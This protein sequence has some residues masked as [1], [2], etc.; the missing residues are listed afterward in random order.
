MT[1]T[2]N[3]FYVP[4]N[5]TNFLP[6]EYI[7]ASRSQ[8]LPQTYGPIILFIGSSLFFTAIIFLSVYILFRNIDNEIV[9]KTIVIISLCLGIL[10]AYMFPSLSLGFLEFF[11]YF[12]LLILII[13]LYAIFRMT[14]LPHKSVSHYSTKLDRMKMEEIKKAIEE[15]S[16]LDEAALEE[17]SKSKYKNLEVIYN[18]LSGSPGE[19]GLAKLA[20]AYKKAKSEEE[21]KEIM[22]R[23]ISSLIESGKLKVKTEKDLEKLINLINL[24]LGLND[25]NHKK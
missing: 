19:K 14:L 21:R 2:I 6:R 12:I 16:Q 17:L 24:T 18:F 23:V 15:L 3:L 5:P 13:I 22:K 8:G 9:R 1:N 10:L 25:K 4:Y 7:Y 20:K 11:Q